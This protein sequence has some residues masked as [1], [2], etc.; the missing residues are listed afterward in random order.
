MCL[1]VISQQEVIVKIDREDFV[2][3]RW[4]KC[5]IP[6]IVSTIISKNKTTEYLFISYRESKKRTK[7]SVLKS[8][9]IV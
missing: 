2:T 9:L 8:L 5:T 4:L 6:E 3:R 7:L 1:S